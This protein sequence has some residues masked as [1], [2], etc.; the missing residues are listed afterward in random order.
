ML[1]VPEFNST[2]S[3]A[4]PRANDQAQSSLSTQSYLTNIRG[5]RSQAK[6]ARLL[7]A[8]LGSLLL[9]GNPASDSTPR[10]NPVEPRPQPWRGFGHSGCVLPA[11]SACA[12]TA[13]NSTNLEGAEAKTRNRSSR[14][15][16]RSARGR[17][18]RARAS[19]SSRGAGT[20]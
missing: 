2:A 10:P 17:P 13:G 15:V 4:T 19:A 14:R 11:L 5:K 9:P 3:A 7:L 8:Q 1:A 18:L 12:L 20:S 16:R 6:P